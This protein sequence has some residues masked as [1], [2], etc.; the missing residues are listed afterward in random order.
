MQDALRDL[1]DEKE[2]SVESSWNQ[3][4][5]DLKRIKLERKCLNEQV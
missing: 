1:E 2:A 4:L 5:E 3:L